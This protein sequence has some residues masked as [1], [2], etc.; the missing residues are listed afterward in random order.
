MNL[1]DRFDV[2]A[3]HVQRLLREQFPSWRISRDQVG[4]WVAEHE[5]WG[6]V[7]ANSASELREELEHRGHR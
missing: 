7:C 3:G 1:D 2:I 6:V 5:V 4:G